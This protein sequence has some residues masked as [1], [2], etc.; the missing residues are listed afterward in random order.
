[1]RRDVFARPNCP[2]RSAPCYAAGVAKLFKQAKQTAGVSVVLTAASLLVGWGSCSDSGQSGPDSGAGTDASAG[3]DGA[4]ASGDAAT[5]GGGAVLIE[6]AVPDDGEAAAGRAACSFAAGAPAAQTLDPGTP[7]GTDMPIDN[8][9]VLMMENH[10]F[11]SYFAHLN[12]YAHRSDIESAP[13]TATNPGA[14]G[15]PQPFTHAAHPCV[16]DTNHEWAGTH[17]EIDNGKMDGFVLAN[18]GWNRSALPPTSTDPALWSGARAMEWY[19]ERDI[20]LYYQLASTFAI[21]DHYHSAVPGPTWP[22][23]MYL[24]AATSFGETTSTEPDLSAYPYP[25]K[26]ATVLDEL[27]KNG[28]SWML[29]SDGP[30]GATIVY[31]A[32]LLTRWGRTVAAPFAQFQ[33]Q[34]AAGT[35]PQVSFVDPNM[36]S[37]ITGAAGSDEHPPGDI[38]VGQQFVGQVVQ[39]VMASPQWAHIALFVMHDEH[40]GFYDHVAPPK[41]CAPDATPPMID[42][43]DAGDAGGFDLDGVRVVLIAVSPYAKKSYV[44]HHVYDHTS[45]TRFIEA[46]F[47]LPALTARDANAETPTDLFDFS[48]PA[49]A[50]PPAIST[51]TV[52]ATELAYCQATYGVGSPTIPTDF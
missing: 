16:L 7:T 20:P 43:G 9:V 44:G 45:I 37:E 46:K 21:A 49:F 14:D 30:P 17:E 12:A 6:G 39:A 40:G 3:P 32:S 13:D 24:Y 48:T 51:P 27:E 29:Y 52:D 31:G 19:D 36:A 23:R 1:V 2:E 35:L 41:V 22:N 5:D 38:Q 26:S 33:S 10:S 34:A 47:A 25:A 42:A 18:E 8:I 4:V 28:T 50:T 15:Q 11:D